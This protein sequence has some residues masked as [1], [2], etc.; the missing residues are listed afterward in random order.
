MDEPHKWMGKDHRKVRHDIFTVALLG[1]TKGKEAATHA[2][3]HIIT[4]TVFTKGYNEMM[5]FAK[6]IVNSAFGDILKF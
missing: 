1:M 6:G 4:D 3:S 2:V 5:K